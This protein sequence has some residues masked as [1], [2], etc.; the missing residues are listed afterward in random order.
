MQEG[1][2]LLSLKSLENQNVLDTLIFFE[3]TIR[4]ITVMLD[5][6]QICKRWAIDERK[7]EGGYNTSASSPG[8][9]LSDIFYT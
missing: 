4:R 9:S 6:T 1:V 8:I 5:D 2:N 7:G 3:I